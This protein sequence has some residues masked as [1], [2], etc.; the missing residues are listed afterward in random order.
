MTRSVV[1]IYGSLNQDEYSRRDHEIYFTIARI[2]KND[3][4]IGANW[5]QYWYGRNL[6]IFVNLTRITESDDE[7]ILLIIGASIYPFQR[8]TVGTSELGQPFRVLQ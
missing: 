6:K 1:E 5:V 4:Y 7:R 8:E 2:G 3:Q